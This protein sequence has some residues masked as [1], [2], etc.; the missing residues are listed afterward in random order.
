MYFMAS[1]K[2]ENFK[3]RIICVLELIKQ[4]I[5]LFQALNDNVVVPAAQTTFCAAATNC[6][7]M[8]LANTR[9]ELFYAD[10][11][12]RANVLAEAFAFMGIVASNP[13]R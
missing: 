12:V 3:L 2:F 13:A 9:H 6:K 8:P 4:P 7:L 11:N 1:Y 10:D 5:L